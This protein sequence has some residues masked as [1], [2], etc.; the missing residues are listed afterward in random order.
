MRGEKKKLKRSVSLSLSHANPRRETAFYS[1]RTQKKAT[2]CLLSYICIINALFLS[3]SL[4]IYICMYVYIYIYMT[5][6]TFCL[7]ISYHSQQPTQLIT[8][9][10]MHKGCKNRNLISIN[11]QICV[12]IEIHHIPYLS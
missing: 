8:Y 2:L 6:N 12:Q 10:S 4:Y 3:L 5:T 11:G 9:L 7:L 1:P